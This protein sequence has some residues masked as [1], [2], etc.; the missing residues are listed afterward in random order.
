[1]NTNAVG[2]YHIVSKAS[3][4]EV[5]QRVNELV[6]SHRMRVVAKPDVASLINP[7]RPL[8]L[9]YSPACEKL[10]L[11]IERQ[12]VEATLSRYLDFPVVCP[13]S[14]DLQ[15]PLTSGPGASLGRLTHY[16]WGEITKTDSV[17]AHAQ[18]SEHVENLLVST[19]LT[20]LRHSYS[21]VLA[22][23]AAPVCLKRVEEYIAEHLLDGVSLDDMLIVSGANLRA[24]YTAFKRYRNTT[25]VAY[26]RGMRLE[27]SQ[28]ELLDS[29]STFK[30]VTDVA[31]A[32][33]F[34]HFGRFASEYGRRFGERPSDTLR[35]RRLA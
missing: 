33:G 12:V 30:T 7:R 16:V 5:S 32:C 8:T 17:L 28:R 20:S 29:H 31:S 19:M 15:L 2:D 25:P 27:R 26:L 10:I 22:K 4:A 35:R 9:V 18:S 23:P 6:G 1:M 24:L 11:R 21:E 34:L 14:F 3:P 13:V